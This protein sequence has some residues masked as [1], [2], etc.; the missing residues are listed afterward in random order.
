[1]TDESELSGAPAKRAPKP[2]PT[3]IGDHKLHP[4]TLMMGHGF[5]PA[6]SE[7]SL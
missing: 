3:A 2:S 1:M 6:L 4:S 5:D 7:G